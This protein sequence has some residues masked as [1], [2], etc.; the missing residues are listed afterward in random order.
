MCKLVAFGIAV[1]AL[2]ITHSISNA[3]QVS[4]AANWAGAY[5]GLSAGARWADN[6][7]NTT[8]VAP[9]L[10]AI[11]SNDP[12]PNGSFDSVAARIGGYLGYNW[13]IAPSWIAGIEADIGWADNKKGFAPIPGTVQNDL[14]AIF[15][16]I[17]QPRGSV[18][19]TW[20]ASV[21][22]RLGALVAPDILLFG[23]AGV[24][25][26]HVELTAM[27]P[28]SGGATDWCTLPH[29]E[30]HA[31]IMTGWTVGGG[32]ERMIGRWIVRAD[33]RYADFGTFSQTFFTFDTAA[34]FDDRFTANVKVRTHTANIGI[35]YR[36]GGQ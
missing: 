34:V 4:A 23:T 22:G 12:N 25:W 18:S 17:N 21:R 30:S 7:W 31:N 3:Q 29:N 19:E 33:Y 32:L 5:G 9:T 1:F 36:F 10:A 24:A 15:S 6:G 14:V 28:A 26:Q 35:A 13:L 11:L 2:A 27:C 20:D 8:N 16:Y